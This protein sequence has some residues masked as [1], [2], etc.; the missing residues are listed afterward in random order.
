MSLPT[1]STQH[2]PQDSRGHTEPNIELED[3]EQVT[4]EALQT[5]IP[6]MGH[7]SKVRVLCHDTICA[8]L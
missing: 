8:E 3:S 2:T 4:L 6:N 5:T 7:F 1:E